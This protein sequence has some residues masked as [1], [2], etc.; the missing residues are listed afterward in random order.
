MH[1]LSLVSLL[2]LALARAQAGT[3]SSAGAPH[4]SGISAGD[5]GDVFG[6]SDTISQLPPSVTSGQVSS[7]GGGGT[8]TQPPPSHSG[9]TLSVPPKNTGLPNDNSTGPDDT[10]GEPDDDQTGAAVGV[11]A[12]P[13][14]LTFV[15]A[16]MA[17]LVL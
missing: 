12:S 3:A 16:G 6:P 5:P 4:S 7:T 9:S 2:A 10:D 13:A 8:G 15:V 11:Y 17:S 14:V 1:A